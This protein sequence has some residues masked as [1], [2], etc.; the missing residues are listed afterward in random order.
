MKDKDCIFCRIVAGELPSI[1]LYEDDTSVAF[2][3]IN[4]AAHGHLL[5]ISREHAVNMLDIGTD[6]LKGVMA[7]VQKLARAV[8]Q[9]LSPEG[10]SIIQSNGPGA[11]QS[12]EHFHMH[13]LPRS[14]YDDLPLN[15]RLT[16]GDRHA[17]E[18]AAQ[19]IRAALAE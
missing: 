1:P 2:M 10:I 5:V 13:I 9:A 17:I 19:K 12:V 7:T 15:W 14:L 11:A 18:A 16:P 3:D 4:P 8:D 6:Q